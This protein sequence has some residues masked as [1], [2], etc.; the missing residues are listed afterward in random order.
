MDY[1]I[2]VVGK[3]D[4]ITSIGQ[5]SRSFIDLISTNDQFINKLNFINTRPESNLKG[6]PKNVNIISSQTPHFPYF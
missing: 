3:F 4:A 5:H 2:N 6:L 1:C